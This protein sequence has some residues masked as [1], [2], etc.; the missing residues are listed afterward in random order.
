MR[1]ARVII[2]AIAVLAALVVGGVWLWGRRPWRLVATVDGD[3]LTSRDLDIRVEAFCGGRRATEENRRE[4]ARVGIAKQ[5]LLGITRAALG[6][7]S[8]I[9]AASFQET[10]KVLNESAIQGKIDYL[11]GMKENVI[12]GNLIPA[13]TGLREFSKLVVH[14]SAE[15]AA[16]QAAR[17][18]QEYDLNNQ[19]DRNY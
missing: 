9:S 8:F 1:R 12:C 13:G 6:T 5:I 4:M 19:M 11:E 3:A 10:T 7:K 17:L 16:M 15:Y 18:A 14:N 2:L